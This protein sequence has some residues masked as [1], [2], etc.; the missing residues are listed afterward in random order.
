MGKIIPENKRVAVGLSGGVDSAVAAFL[1]Q[2]QGYDVTGVYFKCWEEEG[3]CD[4]GGR[5]SAEK[6]AKHLG[7]KFIDLDFGNKFKEE[8][9]K[10]FVN[11]YSKGRT[12]NPDILCNE[13]VKFGAF[14][15]WAMRSGFDY[16]ATGHYAKCKKGKLLRGRDKTKDQSY[17]LYR[18]PSDRLSKVLFPLGDLTKNNVRL[19]AKVNDIPAMSRP[20]SVDICFVGKATLKDYLSKKIKTEKGNVLDVNGNIVGEHDG[21]W[22]Y[23]IGQRKG[24]R[25]SKYFGKPMYVIGKNLDRNELIIGEEFRTYKKEFEVSDLR[26]ILNN[27]G[28]NFRCRVRI[29][30]LGKLYPAEFSNGKVSSYKKIFGVAPGQSAV[31]YKHSFFNSSGDAV[32][33]GGVIQ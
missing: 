2:K 13:K 22:F 1:L 7:I 32:I 26:W 28:N 5:Q 21:V 3:E 24:F 27:L 17:F 12:P 25:V 33:G 23:T 20:E 14:Y 6:V 8:V 29:R 18:I 4:I 15:D 31:F 11:E 10:Y 30:N 9:I 19:I 16:I